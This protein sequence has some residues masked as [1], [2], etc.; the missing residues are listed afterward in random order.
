MPNEVANPSI[1]TG[2]Q[3]E[4]GIKFILAIGDVPLP[5]AA[6]D[7]NINSTVTDTEASAPITGE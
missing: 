4:D 6:P 2:G 3:C 7:T 1:N 5:S